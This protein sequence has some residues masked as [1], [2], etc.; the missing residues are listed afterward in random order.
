MAKSNDG[1]PESD[2]VT[3][4]AIEEQGLERFLEQVRGELIERSYVS[5]R[6]R[7][8]EIPK[9][10]S[11][12]VRETRTLRSMG[13]WKRDHGSRIEGTAKAVGH[14]PGPTVG[15]QVL[16]PTATG[17]YCRKPEYRGSLYGGSEHLSRQ[18]AAYRER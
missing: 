3:F 6:A 12:K 9:E 13:G 14:S 5:L 10:A 15:A 17:D 7:K 18:D 1:A 4:E 8:K 2:G 11:T 16:D